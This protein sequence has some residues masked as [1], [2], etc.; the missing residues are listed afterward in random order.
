VTAISA[1]AEVTVRDSRQLGPGLPLI[2]MDL[3]QRPWIPITG[4]WFVIEVCGVVARI[5]R[6]PL[7]SI[8]LRTPVSNLRP[9]IP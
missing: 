5:K 2:R 8:E 1:G 7:A 6:S 3:A 4:S 9:V